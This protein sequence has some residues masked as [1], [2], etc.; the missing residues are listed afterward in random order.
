MALTVDQVANE[1]PIPSY[2]FIVAIGDEKIAFS[3]VS[4][5]DINYGLMEYRDGI[6]NYFKMPGLKEAT[7]I[8][9]RKGV[10]RGRNGLYDWIN[11]ISLNK[12]EK[13]DIMISLTDETGSQYLV[14][15]NVADAFPTSL[16]SPTLDAS[17][18]EI[19]I[20][21]VTLTADRVSIQTY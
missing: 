6:G 10:F 8:T 14:T 3:N 11:S 20:Q 4:G 12:V 2:R 9:L 5:L 13:R 1:Y 7:T 21:E 18:N 16:S 15:W 17:S 19:S